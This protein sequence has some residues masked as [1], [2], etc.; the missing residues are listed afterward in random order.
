MGEVMRSG[1]QNFRIHRWGSFPQ[2]VIGH[3][4]LSPHCSSDADKSYSLKMQMPPRFTKSEYALWLRCLAIW[5]AMTDAPRNRQALL[6]ARALESQA[7][8]I[9]INSTSPT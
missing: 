4:S 7:E 2:F 6:I 9:A 1:N 5:L 3:Y 8:E